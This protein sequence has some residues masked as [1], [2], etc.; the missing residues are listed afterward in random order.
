[1]KLLFKQKIFSWFDS[2]NIYDEDDNIYFK[3]EGKLSLGHKFIIYDKNG[4]EVGTIKQKLVTLLPEYQIYENGNYIGR[5]Q[6]KF[7]MLHPKFDLDFNGWSVEGDILSLDYKILN[8][9]QEV[10]MDLSKQIFNLVDTYILDIKNERD[11][12][13]ALMIVIAIDAEKDNRN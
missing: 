10:V 11:A 4:N 8:S 6:K 9:N 3:V 5:I 13:Y 2:Y 12:L 1:M 7:T